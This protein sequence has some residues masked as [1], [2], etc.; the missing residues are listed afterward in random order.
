MDHQYSIWCDNLN[1][2]VKFDSTVILD[3]EVFDL[4]TIVKYYKQTNKDID[5]WLNNHNDLL[6]MIENVTTGCDN[7]ISERTI[8][9]LK[10]NWYVNENVLIEYLYDIDVRFM[11]EVISQLSYNRINQ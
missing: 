5:N 7:N 9:K 11:H 3:V 8:I 1:E 4:T 6:H 10:D 2:F